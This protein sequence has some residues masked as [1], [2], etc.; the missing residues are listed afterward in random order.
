[1]HKHVTRTVIDLIDLK[2][3]R[4]LAQIHQTVCP[5]SHKTCIQL[6]GGYTPGLIVVQ[7]PA[8]CM[9]NILNGN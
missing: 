3:V 1:M 4:D 8:V 7:L 5:L 2:S 9:Y 6:S